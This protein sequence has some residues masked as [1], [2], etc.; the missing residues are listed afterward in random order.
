MSHGREPWI[1]LLA[2]VALAGALGVLLPSTAIATQCVIFAIAAIGGTFL[3]GKVGLLSFAQ[4]VYFGTAGYCAALAGIHWHVGA[5]GMLGAGVGAAGAAGAVVGLVATRR[6]GVYFIMMTLA[7]GQLAFFVAYVASD[8]TGGDNGL[9]GVPRPPLSVADWRLAS[10]ESSAAFYAF[11]TAC[12]LVTY[13]LLHCVSRSPFGSVLASIRENEDRSIA[14]G[15]NV[16]LF[17]VLA[18]AVSAAA[19]GVAGSLYVMFL[20]FAP[21]SNIDFTMVEHLVLI[22]L[23]GGTGSLMGGILGG[24]AYELVSHLLAAAWDRWLLPLGAVFVVVGVWFQGGL[25]GAV[26][27]ALARFRGAPPKEARRDASHS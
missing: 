9:A 21:L 17:K 15:Y 16:Y 27:S 24:M 8:V 20:R 3:L 25:W 7:L 12:L 13:Y 26:D 5:L 23:F 11:A 1:D 6:R 18:M 10:L 22:T 4:A 14:A 2:I 19:T